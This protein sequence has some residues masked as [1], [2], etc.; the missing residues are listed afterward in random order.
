MLFKS[1]ELQEHFDNILDTF[2]GADGGVRF[3]KLKMLLNTMEKHADNGDT[4]AKMILDMMIRFSRLIN[5]AND[6]KTY[7]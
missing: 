5:V 3:I 7:E 1:S 2:G 6:G 4:S